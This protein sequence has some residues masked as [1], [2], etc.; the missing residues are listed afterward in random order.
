MKCF[1][2]FSVLRIYANSVSSVKAKANYFEFKAKFDI[3][4][5]S[6]FDMFVNGI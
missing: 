4:K 1:P 5:D 2:V 3:K 6:A